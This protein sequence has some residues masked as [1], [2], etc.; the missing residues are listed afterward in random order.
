MV[1]AVRDYF[2]QQ[3]VSPQ[4]FYY[5]KFADT[6]LVTETGSEHLTAEASDEAFDAKL[7]LELGA[8]SLVIGKLTADQLATYRGLAEATVPYIQDGRF[9]DVEGFRRTN[10]AFHAFLIEGTGNAVLRDAYQRLAIAEYMAEAL[11]PRLAAS[12]QITQDHLDLVGAFERGSLD[13][14]QR[15]LVEH[16]ERSKETMRAGI[17]QAAGTT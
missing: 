15:I 8:A 17:Q 1:D 7:A 9:T 6:G 2:K 13:V 14:A 16:N 5:E 4:N 10:A 12:Q 11:R 3:G